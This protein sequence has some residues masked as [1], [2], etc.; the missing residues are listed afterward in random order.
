MSAVHGGPENLGTAQPASTVK[1]MA[2]RFTACFGSRTGQM[3]G[4][5]DAVDAGPSDSVVLDVRGMWCTSC[6][7]AVERVLQRQPGVLDAKVSFASESALLQWDPAATSLSRV[8]S[9]AAKLGYQCVPEGMGHDRRAHFARVKSDLSIRLIVALFFSMWVMVAQWALYLAPDGSIVPAV[10]YWLALFA[11]VTTLPIIGYCAAPF[12]RA[13][14]RT[15]RARAP[16]MDLLVAMGASASCLLSAWRL[17]EGQATVYF[18]SAAMIVTFLLVGRLLE[19]A[20]R[21]K[22]S[23]A[24]RS[25]LELPPETAHVVDA[26]GSETC[27]LAKRV[28]IHDVIRIRPGERVPLDGVIT[29]GISSL[30]RSMLTGE[31]AFK[32]VAPGDSVEAGTLN[33]DGELLVSVRGTWGQRRVDLIA[34]N[35]RQM[36]A[37]KTATQALAEQFTRYLVPAICVLALLTFVCTWAN[38]TD[39]GLAIE[40]AVSVL[41]V[42]CPCALGMAVPLALTAGVGRAARAGVFFRD[43]EAIEKAGHIDHFF[44]DKTGTLTE[45]TPQL[46]EVRLAPGVSK[47][48]LLDEA[49]TAERG[50]EHPLAKAIMSC[51]STAHAQ[52]VRAP[53][54]TSRAT[55]GGG[56][57]WTGDDTTRI[58]V[59]SSRYLSTHDIRSP[60]IVA[61]HTQVHVARDGQWRGCLLFSDTPRPGTKHAL[62][63]LRSGG[64]GLAILTGDDMSVA[65]RIADAV[66]MDGDAIYASQSPE[67]KSARIVAAQTAGLKVAF[68]GDGL[69]DAPALA[70][71]D[72]GIAVRGASASSVAAAS[73]VLVDGGIEKLNVALTIARRTARAMRQNLAAAAVYNLLAVPM[74][75]IGFV[76]PA[77]AAA[78]MIA[79]SLSVTLNAARLTMRN[80]TQPFANVGP[81]QAHA[82]TH[83]A[84]RD[85]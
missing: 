62:A 9:H 21:S 41:V 52:P 74:A 18:D 8:L 65:L 4:A 39:I 76:S 81:S 78:L 17:L 12:F 11:G 82:D 33:A 16:G 6:A 37:R 5:G 83:R 47:A 26:N 7:N 50:S 30:D 2:T 84:Q 34:Q 3:A 1:M 48:T 42:T 10:Q 61:D 77:M 70:A 32:T 85:G 51:A 38:G 69:N 55:P 14:W 79:S 66:G 46:V 24:V 45:G 15:V 19:A 25:L 53:R 80:S 35:I 13:A 20:V 49:A 60:Q 58:V 40:R 36:L 73:I 29:Q 43:V 72:L 67:A 54:G 44:L 75:V 23:D 64:V 27:V 22:S 28:S 68:V 57:E 31:T 71:A 59:G 56:V 63:D